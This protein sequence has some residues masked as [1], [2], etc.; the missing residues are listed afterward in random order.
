[1]SFCKPFGRFESKQRCL[2]L[3]NGMIILRFNHLLG[4]RIA[5]MGNRW[6]GV[7]QQR[8]LAGGILVPPQ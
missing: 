7:L 4:P 6:V 2:V 5:G 8:M 3:S 1:M